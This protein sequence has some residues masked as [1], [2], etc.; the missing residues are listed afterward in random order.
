MFSYLLLGEVAGLDIDSTG[1]IFAAIDRY[2][3]C[4]VSNVDTNKGIFW[5]KTCSGIQYGKPFF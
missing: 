5:L 1:E 2:G 4:F 3:K